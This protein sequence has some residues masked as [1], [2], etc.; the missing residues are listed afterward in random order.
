MSRRHHLAALL[1]LAAPA[2]AQTVNIVNGTATTETRYDIV[3]L[4]DGYQLTE[5]AQFDS[6]VTTFLTALFQKEPYLTFSSYYNVHTVFRASQES[7]ADRPDETPPIYRNTVYD[8]TYNYGGTARCLYIQNQTAALADAALAPATEGRVLVMVNDDRYGGC[9]STFAVSYNGSQMS[10][11]Q[12]HELGHSLGQVADEY[13]YAGQTYT[14][15]EPSSANLTIDPAGSKWQ[16]WQGT[17]GISSFQGGGY[18]QYG[19]YRPRNNCL[20]RSLGAPLCRVCQENITLITNSHVHV[21]TST[22]PDAAATVQVVAPAPQTFAF[23]HFVPAT[24]NPLIEWQVDGVV[25]PG[26]NGLS[27]T[28]DSTQVSLGPHTITATILDQTDRVRRDP[29]NVMLERVDWSVQVSD[30]SLAQLRVAS[31]TSSG[32]LIPPGGAATYTPY[33][34]NDGP[35]A[36]GPFR[37]EFFLNQDPS[38]VTLQDV[39]LGAVDV[40]GLAAGQQVQVPLPTRLPYSLPLYASWVHAVVD[41]AN[42]VAES[43]ENDNSAQRVVFVP[44]IPCSTGLELQDPM[45]QPFSASISRG[46]GAT[47][48]PT[49]LA[50]CA[51][52]TTRLYLIAWGGSGTSPGTNL[53]PGVTLPLNADAL[54]QLG[55]AGLNG[56]AFGQF[57]GLL[58]AQGRAQATLTIPPSAAIPTGSTHLAAVILGPPQVFAAASNPIELVVLP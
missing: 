9:A 58:D 38:G 17:Q 16:I 13:E 20:M 40:P 57:A 14:G 29:Q 7:G 19:I 48:H 8:A 23:T 44:T 39:Y 36:A 51:A 25:Q 28:L 11:V 32:T 49:L 43:D 56:P 45:T 37:V 2:W 31:M 5:E 34:A 55:L 53:A 50:P 22:A 54:T 46:A 4:G 15:G 24:N 33:V 42:A 47:L 1:L 21:V 27:F 35:A 18:N 52:P 26:A 30:P 12:A 10:E 41:R 6:D 3:I